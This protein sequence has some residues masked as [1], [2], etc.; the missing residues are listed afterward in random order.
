VILAAYNEARAL[1]G[2][3]SSLAGLGELSGDLCFVVVD[4]GSSDG[5]VEAAARCGAEVVSHSSNRG[6]GAALLT[7]LR[8][9]RDADVV[10][11]MDADGTAGLEVA[12]RLLVS[13]VGGARVAVASLY[14]AGAEVK[15]VP[16]W[17]RA[18]SRAASGLVRWSWT[19]RCGTVRRGSGRTPV[20]SCAGCC[21]AWGC[22]G[23]LP[24]AG[25]TG[26]TS[27]EV[28]ALCGQGG[29]GAAVAGLLGAGPTRLHLG[30]GSLEAL[31]WVAKAALL[32]R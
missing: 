6:L 29:G 9:A 31:G 17:R 26:G 18:L 27:V 28:P 11:T 13:V 4:D 2:L 10:L 19:S 25:V 15:G 23:D 22:P 7:A 32:G 5:T 1:P 8:V 12:T 20:A 24:R 14:V 21:L 30:R 16:F 3:L